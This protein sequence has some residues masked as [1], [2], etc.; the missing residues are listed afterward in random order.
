MTTFWID[1]TGRLI[2]ASS[3]P[4][5]TPAGAVTSTETAPDSAKHQSWDG[6]AWVDDADRIQQEQRRADLL[7]LIDAGKDVA[8]VLVE[9]I[10]WQLA[11]TAMQATDFSA[12]V[13]QAFLDL[14]T[15]ADRLRAP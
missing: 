6:A 10:E 2:S 8:L 5:A 14:Q 11:N 1:A 4:T 3:D 15:I 9:L 13:K 7:T 12:D